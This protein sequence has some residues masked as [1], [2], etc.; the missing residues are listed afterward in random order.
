MSQS[1][2]PGR[3]PGLPIPLVTRQVTAASRQQSANQLLANNCVGY[4][5]VIS[6][7]F[8]FEQE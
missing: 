2:G 6:F 5:G 7:S 3:A 8:W 4:C 1:P